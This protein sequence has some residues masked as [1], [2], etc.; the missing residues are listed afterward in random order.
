L[1]RRARGERA[2]TARYG[3]MVR[4]SEPKE[5]RDV[6]APGRER[7]GMELRAAGKHGETG[8]IHP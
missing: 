2:L 6:R 5:L 3:V 7:A 1:R 4:V 8:V